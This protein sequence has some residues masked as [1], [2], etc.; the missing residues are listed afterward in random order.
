MGKQLGDVDESGFEDLPAYKFAEYFNSKDLSRNPIGSGP[1]KLKEWVSND[2][3][4]LERDP[5]Y[6]GYKAGITEKH[7]ASR[8]SYLF[9]QE[10]GDG[11]SY[12]PIIASGKNGALPHATPSEKIIEKAKSALEQDFKPISDMRASRKYRMEVAKNLLHKCFLEITQKKL[13]RVNN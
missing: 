7:I 3:I 2:K 11:D 10:G 12:D 4:V 5:N 6:W 13:I 1:Y 8:I 9:K